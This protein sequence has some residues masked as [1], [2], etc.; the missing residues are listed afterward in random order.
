MS[1]VNGEEHTQGEGWRETFPIGSADESVESRRQFL[2]T[3]VAASV[4]IACGQGVLLAAD[5]RRVSTVQLSDKRVLLDIQVSDLAVGAAAIFNYPISHNAHEPCIIVRLTDKDFVAYSQKCTHLACPVVP[6]VV[7][8]KMICP[9]H[10]GAFDIHTGRALYG[11]PKTALPR[12][13][14]EISPSGQIYALGM[15]QER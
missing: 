1:E 9:C 14:L 15:E 11:P 10:N 8:E 6:D 7:A 12:V 2:K 5:A 3:M 4:V 13:L